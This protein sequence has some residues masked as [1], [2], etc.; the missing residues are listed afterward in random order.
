MVNNIYHLNYP[1]KRIN[2]A[3]ESMILKEFEDVFKTE[4]GELNL[5]TAGKHKIKTNTNLPIFNRSGSK[6]FSK[7]L[8]PLNND[9][10]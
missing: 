5:C 2:M 8:I 3:E 4:I 10:K 1:H 7:I 6:G 9:I